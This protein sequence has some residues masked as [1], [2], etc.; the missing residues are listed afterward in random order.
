[1]MKIVSNNGKT[2]SFMYKWHA[3]FMQ[4]MK[5]VASMHS[6]SG[7]KTLTALVCP[8]R[9]RLAQLILLRFKKSGLK[10]S[11]YPFGKEKSQLNWHGTHRQNQSKRLI[12]KGRKIVLFLRNEPA[13]HQQKPRNYRW[14]FNSKSN[15]SI[16]TKASSV[17][18]FLVF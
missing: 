9:G 12:F 2:H 1:M 17:C 6:F 14:N 13:F 4:Y 5:Q 18:I 7:F 10:K 15:Q 8:L 16:E 11:C 3:S